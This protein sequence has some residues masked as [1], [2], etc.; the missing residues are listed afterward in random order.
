MIHLVKFLVKVI[1]FIIYIPSFYFL[2]FVTIIM[3]DKRII[4]N[5]EEIFDL[6][7]HNTDKR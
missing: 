6:I 4:E 1:A 7:W 3:W 2:L 5:A